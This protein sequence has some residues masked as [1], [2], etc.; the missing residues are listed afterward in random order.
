[1]RF[2]SLSEWLNWIKSLHVTDMDLSLERVTAVAERLGVLA[3]ACQVITVGGTNGKGSTVAG[4]EAIYLAQGYRV[5]AFTTPFLF[6]HNEQVRIQGEP[7]SDE[8]FCQAYEQIAAALAGVTLTP[9][10]FN[11]LA[12]FII[13]KQANLDVW[14]LE[15]GMGGRY[16]AVNIIN[17]DVAVVT[18]IGIDHTQW[19]GNT[20]EAIAREKAGIFRGEKPAVYGDFDPPQSLIEIAERL[21]VPLYRQGKEFNFSNEVGSWNWQSKKALLE[22][23][24]LTKLALQNMASVLMAIELSQSRLPVAITAI[25]QGLTNVMLPGRIQVVPGAVTQVFDVSHNP[26]AAEWLA[27]WLQKNP[28]KGIT[29]A[30]FS[31]LAD[32]DISATLAVVKPFINHWYIAPI[33]DARAATLEKLQQCFLKSSIEKVTSF[34]TLKNAHL[35]ALKAAK[36]E[37]RIVIFGSFKTVAE[38]Y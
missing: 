18:S 9:F 35:A 12:A 7:A 6:R 20:R 25:H 2:S 32:K 13:F 17:A 26:A 8:L 37:D 11:A 15:V 19:L 16:D 14:L 31:M 23:L 38:T 3:L 22:K 33:Q 1:M 4:L 24:P 21:N 34:S 30:V 10:E 27:E 28:I 29:R 36:S 5:G